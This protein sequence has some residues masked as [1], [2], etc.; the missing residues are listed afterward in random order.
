MKSLLLLVLVAFGPALWTNSIYASHLGPSEPDLDSALIVLKEGSLPQEMCVQGE[1]GVF[2]LHSKIG[3]DGRPIDVQLVG[4]DNERLESGVIE[5]G[6]TF[7]FRAPTE[8][9]EPVEASVILILNIINTSDSIVGRRRCRLEYSLA[10]GLEEIDEFDPPTL[11]TRF[12]PIYP[13]MAAQMGIEGRVVVGM[14]V[15][16]R[17]CRPSS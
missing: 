12:T 11:L 16:R 6:K 10:S 8:D 13:V 15:I 3:T 17:G 2:L 14:F 4:T 1:S 7:S 5:T 9:G